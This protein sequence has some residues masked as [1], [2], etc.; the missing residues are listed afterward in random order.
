M[1]S[2]RLEYSIDVDSDN[3]IIYAKIFG[4]WKEDAAESYH[5]DFKAAL[6]PL[7]A[8]PWAKLIDLS[9]WKTSYPEV[10]DVIGKHMDWSMKHN[11]ALSI[12]VLNNTST[13]RQLN[14]MF[15]KGGVKDVAMTFRTMVEAEKYLKQH[16]LPKQS[17]STKAG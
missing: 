16:W 11:C 15:A 10:V 8:K 3:Q 14:Q 9:N 13:F 6:E 5:A 4:L 2:W 12:Y 17:K 7:M 1:T